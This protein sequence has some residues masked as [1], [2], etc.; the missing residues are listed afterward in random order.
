M[1]KKWKYL[2]L[3]IGVFIIAIIVIAVVGSM[4]YYSTTTVSTTCGQNGQ[5]VPCSTTTLTCPPFCATG[6]S[7]TGNSISLQDVS[8]C[9][10]NCLYGSP[11]LSAT[12]YVDGSV[13]LSTLHWF[14]NGTDEGTTIGPNATVSYA[15]N[16]LYTNYTVGYTV[17]P[18][19]PAMPIIAGETYTIKVVST[20]QDNSTYTAS[21][22][23]VASSGA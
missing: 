19:N 6:I 20:F 14:I 1:N 3:G 23:V 7:T 11:E 16:L 8:L 15:T 17:H 22:T 18:N 2:L 12:I 21:A 9:A 4:V 13:R 10:I 5:I